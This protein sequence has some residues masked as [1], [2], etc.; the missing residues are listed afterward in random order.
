MD[1]TPLHFLFVAALFGGI[2]CDRYVGT[3]FPFFTIVFI[4]MS[5]IIYYTVTKN[6]NGEEE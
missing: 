5:G 2:L 1:K 3:S 6:T 4:A